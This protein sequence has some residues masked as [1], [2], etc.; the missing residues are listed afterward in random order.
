MNCRTWQPYNEILVNGQ[1][2]RQVT[3]VPN[4]TTFDVVGMAMVIGVFVVI[5]YAFT[6]LKS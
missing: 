4:S 5:G 6:K 3:T 2:V 1:C